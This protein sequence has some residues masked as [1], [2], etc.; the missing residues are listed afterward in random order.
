MQCRTAAAVPHWGAGFGLS[1]R[2]GRLR[3]R[4]WAWVTETPGLLMMYGNWLRY[5]IHLTC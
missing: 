3:L 4:L 1:V 2:Q 5:P